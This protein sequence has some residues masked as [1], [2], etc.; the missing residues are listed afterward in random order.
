MKKT[1]RLSEAERAVLNARGNPYWSLQLEDE[2]PVQ[3]PTLEEKRAYLRK[4]ENPAA[5]HDVMGDSPSVTSDVAPVPSQRDTAKRPTIR[6][7]SK[8]DFQ[9]GCRRIFGQYMPATERG[10]LRDHH[11]AFIVRNENS[12][13]AR[14]AALMGHLQRYDLSA[15]AGI[16]PQFNRERDVLTEAKLRAI[17]KAADQVEG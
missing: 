10:R 9:Q 12:T 16:S 6:G 8:A 14:R 11:R 5:Y 13:P 4:L 17:E 2:D 15:I 3:E 7:V 1:R